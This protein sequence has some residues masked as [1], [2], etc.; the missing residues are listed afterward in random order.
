VRLMGRRQLG[1][2]GLF[3]RLVPVLSVLD[4]VLPW[5]FGLQV[6]AIARKPA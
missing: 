5:P 1:G 6:I 2:V 4:R 3:D